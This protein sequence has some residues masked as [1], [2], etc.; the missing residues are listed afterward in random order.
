ML[1]IDELNRKCEEKNVALTNGH[2]LQ[3]DD[4]KLGKLE[5][6]VEK[7]ILDNQKLREDV[8]TLSARNQ[9][10]EKEISDLKHK[11]EEKQPGDFPNLEK[12]QMLLTGESDTELSDNVNV[13]NEHI[14]RVSDKMQSIISQANTLL[15][16][17]ATQLERISNLETQLAEIDGKLSHLES[18]DLYLQEA[19]KVLTE[20]TSLIEK[21]SK[22]I[23]EK[24]KLV[25][26]QSLISSVETDDTSRYHLLDQRVTCLERSHLAREKFNENYI[27]MSKRIS[28]E[29]NS[30]TQLSINVLDGKIK[31]SK[32]NSLSNYDELV[33]KYK[34]ILNRIQTME[35]LLTEQ[36]QTI[37]DHSRI[38]SD[39]YF[40]S[41][42]PAD[43][44]KENR[45]TKM[46]TEKISE[47]R[48]EEE[49]SFMNIRDITKLNQANTDVFE[50]IEMLV[51]MNKSL[52]NMTEESVITQNQLK[53]LKTDQSTTLEELSEHEKILKS[54]SDR[55]SLLHEK[56]ELADIK[57]VNKSTYTKSL[58]KNIL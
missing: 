25:S 15:I 49:R 18:A 52:N 40:K 38:F 58:I 16:N 6:K 26:S 54:H 4:D 34:L 7:I 12:N 19:H 37:S 2:G 9:V 47:I 32:M 31:D 46:V 17:D 14:A 53:M 8:Q 56:L 30:I 45:I 13:L 39:K 36:S 42:V 41:S 35:S 28:E 3:N 11:L 50:F 20:R 44:V 27:N 23:E 21:Y 5:E 48:R 33:D 51:T 22:Y 29:S 57:E 24:V 1:H 43:K 55:F 10:L